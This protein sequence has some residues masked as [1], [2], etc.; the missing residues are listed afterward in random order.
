MVEELVGES[1]LAFRHALDRYEPAYG[2]DFVG[3]LSQRLYW[4]LEHRARRLRLGQELQ[5]E[6]RQVEPADREEE[7]ALN[8][9]LATDVLATLAP[10][11]AELLARH[12]QG[13]TDREL[14]AALGASPAAVRKRLERLRRR[15]RARLVAPRG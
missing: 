15:I 10:A 13:Q 5:L 14:A 7:E 12:A 4:M 9:V 8:R 11:D 6:A 1:Y 3:Y 2:V